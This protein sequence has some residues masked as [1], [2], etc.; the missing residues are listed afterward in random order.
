MPVRLRMQK[1]AEKRTEWQAAVTQ[2][3]VMSAPEPDCFL[4][5]ELVKR[6]ALNCTRTVPSRRGTLN[7]SL[8]SSPTSGRLGQMS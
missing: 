8:A 6:I 3:L 2:S 4:E 1:F 5:L 7:I